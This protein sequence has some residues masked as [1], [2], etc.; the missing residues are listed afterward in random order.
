[1]SLIISALIVIL[2]DQVLKYAAFQLLEGPKVVLG[3]LR[4]SQVTNRGVAFGIGS[5]IE[6][7]PWGRYFFLLLSLVIV[8]ALLTLFARYCRT[9]LWARISLGLIVG[10]AISNLADRLMF[11]YVRDFIDLRFWPTF[12]GADLAICSGVVLLIAGMLKEE[13]G[14]KAPVSPPPPNPKL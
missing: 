8:I 3:F 10:G 6:S 9:R 14:R 1:M 11:G 2:A 7:A 5:D 4:L 12:N 13:S